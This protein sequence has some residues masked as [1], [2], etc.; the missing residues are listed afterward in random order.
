[1]Q[2]PRRIK[3]PWRIWVIICVGLG[4]LALV[5][6]FVSR[7]TFWPWVPFTS[8]ALWIIGGI[9]Y[10]VGRQRTGKLLREPRT[11]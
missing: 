2:T 9:F 3:R 4:A 11:R 10:G 5:P 1:M 7:Q 8:V 6:A